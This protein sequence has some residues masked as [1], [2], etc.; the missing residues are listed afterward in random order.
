M[1]VAIL[2]MNWEKV[3]EILNNNIQQ[4]KEK[5]NLKI[6]TKVNGFPVNYENKLSNF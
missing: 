4:L 3:G 6:M 2:T 5:I 1:L